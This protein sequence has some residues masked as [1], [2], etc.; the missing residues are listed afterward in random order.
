M[1]KL[2]F[3]NQKLNLSVADSVRK[4]LHDYVSKVALQQRWHGLRR[5]DL[6]TLEVHDMLEANQFQLKQFI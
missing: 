6:W 1:A 3:E 4:L 5:R 2:K